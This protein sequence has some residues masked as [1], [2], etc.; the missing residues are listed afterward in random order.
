MNDMIDV[1]AF[2]D[3]FDGSCRFDA[4]VMNFAGAPNTPDQSS[5]IVIR[6]FDGNSESFADLKT[7]QGSDR[8]GKIVEAVDSGKVFSVEYSII[9][10]ADEANSHCIR[11]GPGGIRSMV[12]SSKGKPML[13]DHR[14]YDSNSE[15][16]LVLSSVEA[17]L[18]G[19]DSMVSRVSAR[20]QK[21][22]RAF[23]SGMRRKYSSGLIVPKSSISC[24]ACGGKMQSKTLED[25]YAHWSLSCGH[26]IGQQIETGT[27]KKI[28]EYAFSKADFTELSSTPNPAMKSAKALGATLSIY[29]EPIMADQ[30]SS[31]ESVTLGARVKELE[32]KLSEATSERDALKRQLDEAKDLGVKLALDTLK[33]ERFLVGTESD[34]DAKEYFSVVGI[35]RGMAFYRKGK[36]QMQYSSEAFGSTKGNGEPVAPEDGESPKPDAPASVKLSGKSVNNLAEAASVLFGLT[37]NKEG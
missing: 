18:N 1:G 21:F 17:S 10:F 11:P 32:V 37:P 34:A 25:G 24:T 23:L 14:E 29:K 4:T 8:F 2:D 22:Q 35:E 20:D 30:N 15:V 33:A 36:P 31:Q 16:G 3:E 28:V 6:Y 13:Q 5:E 27:G 9:A 26:K 12:A 7:L 19:K